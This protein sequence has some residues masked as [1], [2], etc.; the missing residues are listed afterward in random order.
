MAVITPNNAEYQR[1]LEDGLAVVEEAGEEIDLVTDYVLD[2]GRIP[3]Q[4]VS[5]AGQLVREGITTISCFC[6]PLMLLSLTQQIDAQGL[7]PEWIVTGVGFVDLDLIGQGL[8]KANDQWRRAFGPSPL[9]QQE[10]AGQSAGYRAFKSV[11]PDEEPSITVDVLYYQLYQLALGIQMAGPDLTPE[12]METGL[13]S[14]PEHT[15]PGGTWDYFPES[16]TPITDLREVW[17]DGGKTSLFN[18][19]PGTYDSSN[20]RFGRE[21]LETVPEE[22]LDQQPQVFPDGIPAG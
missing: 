14:Y 7:Q 16:Y 19:D 18:G 2:L 13:F 9:A 15:G 1:C 5:I 6:D 3:A 4:A 10:P 12:T 8:A 20:V 22:A 21:D 11:R 17:W